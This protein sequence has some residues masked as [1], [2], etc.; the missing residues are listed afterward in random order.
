MPTKTQL[1]MRRMFLE[2]SEVQYNR[3][4]HCRDEGVTVKLEGTQI[5]VKFS[6]GCSTPFCNK[7][8]G[9]SKPLIFAVIDNLW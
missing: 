3:Q 5:C 4:V 8:L 7:T 9:I 6:A 1:K 2:F